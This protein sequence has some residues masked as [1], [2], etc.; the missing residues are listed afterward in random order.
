MLRGLKRIFNGL[1]PFSQ[2][3]AHQTAQRNLERLEL[4]DWHGGVAL[5]GEAFLD[6]AGADAR[7]GGDFAAVGDGQVPPMP[8]CP[9]IMQRAP[10]VVEPA[11]PVWA[12]MTV[13]S[14]ITTLWAI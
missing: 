4:L 9:P 1:Q 6:E 14:P 10:T 8:T 13:A 5:V 3:H 7:L 11:M 12:A 2:G